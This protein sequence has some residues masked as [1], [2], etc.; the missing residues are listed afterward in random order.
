MATEVDPIE[1]SCSF[2]RD[3]TLNSAFQANHTTFTQNGDTEDTSPDFTSV[4]SVQLNEFN[5]TDNTTY[6]SDGVI[7]GEELQVNFKKN[8]N[9]QV[10]NN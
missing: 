7:V 8:R 2:T 1:L 4:F 10:L 9:F 5:Y 3:I 6:I